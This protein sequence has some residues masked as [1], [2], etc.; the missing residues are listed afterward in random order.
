[1]MVPSLFARSRNAENRFKDFFATRLS[2][3]HTRRVYYTAICRFGRWCSSHRL[4]TLAQLNS[5]HMVE[6]LADLER[7]LST[8][9]TRQH[10]A[11]LRM[12]F[13]WL[14]AGGVI[15][16]NPV[17]AVR[18]SN[19][20]IVRGKA[21]VLNVDEVHAILKAINIESV[22]G[23][24]DRALIA[25]MVYTFARVGAIANMRVEDYY[26]LG[27]NR[28]VRLRAK[29]SA[30]HEVPVHHTLDLYLQAYIET[31]GL[32]SDPKGP[33]FRTSAGRT[34]VLKRRAMCQDDVYKMIQRRAWRAG[35]RAKIGCHTFRATGITAYLNNGG[36]IEV[37]QRMAGHLNVNTTRLYGW[38]DNEI[39]VG[40]VEKIGI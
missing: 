14:V 34:G 17:H 15:K 33:L 40:E 30:I 10:F 3:L 7:K 4:T 27:P 26:S 6:Y 1:M 35:L 31:T 25:L 39:N 36:R 32:K 2:N 23:L 12:L 16:V 11:A 18:I 38:R 22:V 29:G 9:S 37:A 24:R 8:P 19:Y 20:P 21:H 13:D 5:A 28:S